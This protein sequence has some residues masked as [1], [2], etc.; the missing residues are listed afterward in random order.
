MATLIN[1]VHLVSWFHEIFTNC[2]HPCNQVR[3]RHRTF[4]QFS[5][6]T[7]PVSAHGHPQSCKKNHCLTS[8]TRDSN[9]RI[10]QNWVLILINQEIFTYAILRAI[11][12]SNPGHSFPPSSSLLKQ[13]P[14]SLWKGITSLGPPGST[15]F[16]TFLSCWY[17][18]L[19]HL[20]FS[21][22]RPQ[23]QCL[24]TFN[25]CKPF[26]TIRWF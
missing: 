23:L 2:T 5:S 19:Q 13:E 24:C 9:L 17:K 22:S 16:V 26:C 18:T 25:R 20:S 6:C 4:P 21:I 12:S 7:T 3:S 1:F 8:N 11:R 10:L 14:L 15:P